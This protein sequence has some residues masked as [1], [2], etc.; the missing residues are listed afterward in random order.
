[1]LSFDHNFTFRVENAHSKLKRALKI[2]IDDFKK[3]VNVIKLILK[4]E[5]TKYFI[6]HENAKTHISTNCDIIA[7]EH[8]RDFINFYTLKLIN[9]SIST[10][11]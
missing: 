4:K 1:M 8:V 11:I 5:K 7:F 3:I 6:A 2:F 10:C 9:Y